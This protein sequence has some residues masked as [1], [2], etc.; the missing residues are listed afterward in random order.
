[1]K[2]ITRTL[3]I[4]ILM[5]LTAPLRA[6]AASADEA[7]F[8]Y[9]EHSA[10][11]HEMAELVLHGVE[12]SQP[13]ALLAPMA[14]SAL[15]EAP[16]DPLAHYLAALTAPTPVQAQQEL[17]RAYWLAAASSTPERHFILAQYLREMGDAPSAITL[18]ESLAAE[19]PA[20]RMILMALSQALIDNSQPQLARAHLQ[21]A[22]RLG[23]DTSRVYLLLAQ[24]YLAT[25]HPQQ[26]GLHFRSA[27]ARMHPQAHPAAVYAGLLL[28]S[29]AEDAQVTSRILREYLHRCQENPWGSDPWAPIWMDSEDQAYFYLDGS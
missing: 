21:Q 15:K 12:I 2:A 16:S 27:L 13:K 5:L 17:E 19:R 8:A 24:S 20:D 23:P 26:A 14:Q 22:Q 3:P 18:L 11:T 28:A 29:A 6:G 4:L 25:G 10:H 7:V 9:S 1:M